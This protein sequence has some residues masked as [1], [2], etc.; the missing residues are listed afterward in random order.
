MISCKGENMKLKDDKFKYVQYSGMAFCLFCFLWLV[1]Y[2]VF[3]AQEE[4]GLFYIVQ[5]GDFFLWLDLISKQTGRITFYVLSWFWAGPM[6]YPDP[7]AYKISLCILII[8]DVAVFYRLLYVHVD[9]KFAPFAVTFIIVTFQISEQ[10]N[11][12]ITYN[13]L[14]IPFILLVLS[15]HAL[16]D[17]CK[18]K[19]GYGAVIFSA[20]L[21]LFASYFQENFVLFY[22]LSFLIVFAF[23]AGHFWKRVRVSLWKL[24]F[25]VLGGIIFLSSYFAFR[26]AFGD[27]AYGGNTLCLTQPAVSI[28]VLAKFMTGMFPGRTFGVLK[29]RI[30][31]GELSNCVG[32]K[33]ICVVVISVVFIS[34]L[35]WRT[36]SFKKSKWLVG[37]LVLSSVL[38]CVLHSV[39][40]QYIDWVQNGA[41]YSYVPSY[42]SSF[43]V[44]TIIC[45]IVCEIS[46]RLK[47]VLKKGFIVL[48]GV[49]A[50]IVM[51]MTM[52]SNHY[53]SNMYH[54]K[55]D[56]YE[57]YREFF[58]ESDVAQWEEEAQ[59]L[60]VDEYP[61]YI[62]D[63]KQCM[64]TVR[65]DA[66]FFNIT[67]NINDLD[68]GKP[69]YRLEYENDRIKAKL[70]E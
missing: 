26:R 33:D 25:H 16:L 5:K 50:G 17:Y 41:A 40:Q 35:L 67:D 61:V 29:D 13:Y 10:H 9:K 36:E 4:Y 19:K 34:V 37:G 6:L 28:K 53:Y 65:Y 59:V 24:K 63:I 43:F 46:G 27:E 55:L 2:T 64:T 68:P 15:A 12:L 3:G 57:T 48:S 42:Y 52:A 47:G 45:L 22:I 51:L 60:I 18:G 44:N 8:L 30:S 1:R 21:S 32:M 11:L 7:I 70:I 20:V 31:W 62:I 38:A 69:Y 66:L 23:Q 49:A 54:E 14:H 56:H 58:Q 39:S